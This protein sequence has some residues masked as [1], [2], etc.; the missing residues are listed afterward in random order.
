MRT[1]VEF[2]NRGIWQWR[3][4]LCPFEQLLET[5]LPLRFPEDTADDGRPD[6]LTQKGNSIVASAKNN[7]SI[8]HP[9]F[10]GGR[11]T[12]VEGDPGII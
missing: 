3:V 12:A 11:H 7:D 6:G 9:Q 1:N 5:Q 8:R 10:R 4:C 2:I